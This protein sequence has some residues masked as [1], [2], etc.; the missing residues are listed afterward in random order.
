MCFGGPAPDKDQQA[1]TELS[2][3]QAF[4]N[5]INSGNW[6]T[7]LLGTKPQG[8]D[9][10]TTSEQRSSAKLYGDRTVS[11]VRDQQQATDKGILGADYLDPTTGMKAGGPPKAPDLTDALLQ[12]TRTNFA[13]RLQAGK[14]QSSSFSGA[15]LGGLDLGGDILGGK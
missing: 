3:Y 10:L 15:Q 6:D 5:A 12:K 8:W 4:N 11:M 13:L 2:R 7:S 9:S 1:T 14:N